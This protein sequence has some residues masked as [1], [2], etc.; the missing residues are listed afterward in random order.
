[1]WHVHQPDGWLE[2]VPEHEMWVAVCQ[3]PGVMLDAAT[4]NADLG[5]PRE[6]DVVRQLR[7]DLPRCQA[8]VDGV[9]TCDAQ[10]VLTHTVHPRMCTQ[11]AF[12][13]VLEWVHATGRI[14]HEIGQPLHVDVTTG[15][16]TRLS[17]PLGICTRN[18]ATL[19]NGYSLHPDAD[20]RAHQVQAV[21]TRRW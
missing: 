14:A 10:A 1:M 6:Q 13:P 12:A 2:I 7:V 19:G 8:R 4:F 3:Q 21:C 18:G 16:P 9:R 5:M 20:V 11:A 17:K 15:G